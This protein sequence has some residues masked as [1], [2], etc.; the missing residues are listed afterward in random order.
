MPNQQ[1]Y[2][3]YINGDLMP[4]I[5]V[6]TF[7]SNEI[8]WDKPV[9]EYEVIKPF[10]YD[11]LYEY[12]ESILTAQI[13]IDDFIFNVNRMGFFKLN[14]SRIS[15]RIERV[16]VDPAVI[17]RFVIGTYDLQELITLLP[18]ERKMTLLIR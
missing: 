18:E 10:R 4:Y 7:E 16:G 15:K 17:T 9:L 6:L 1:I 8:N 11:D 5:Y 12:D 14:L 2:Y 13:F 3:E